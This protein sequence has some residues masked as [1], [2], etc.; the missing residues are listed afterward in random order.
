MRLLTEEICLAVPPGHRLAWRGSIRLQEVAREL[1]IAMKPGYDLRDLT[2]GFCRQAG[3][4]PTIVC[5]GD[6]P[7]AI[8][9]LVGAGLGVA[10][11][12]ASS[13][14]LVPEREVVPLHMEEPD[15]VRTIG[16]AWPGARIGSSPWPPARLAGS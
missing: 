10:V 5:E 3:F 16:L 13:W 14:R 1:F 12:L 9:P 6:E 11:L 8:R 15:C 7:A 4:V 2:D